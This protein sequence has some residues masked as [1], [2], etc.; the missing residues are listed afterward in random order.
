MSSQKAKCYLFKPH[1]GHLML[2]VSLDKSLYLHY[3]FHWMP[4]MNWCRAASGSRWLSYAPW[5]QD[6]SSG[7]MHLCAWRRI[8][9]LF[10]D[11]MQ[12]K[13][14]I[15]FQIQVLFCL[16]DIQTQHRKMSDIAEKSIAPSVGS[17]WMEKVKA[18][19]TKT[20][21]PTKLPIRVI[22]DLELTPVYVYT[23][24]LVMYNCILIKIETVQFDF[25]KERTILCETYEVGSACLS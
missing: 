10:L 15:E 13:T 4:K 3:L 5:K 25:V 6:K 23:L 24:V 16:F 2:V 22:W 7:Q 1:Y 20:D 17:R 9:F 8:Y 21:N 19:L 14:C 11:L 12:I 18:F